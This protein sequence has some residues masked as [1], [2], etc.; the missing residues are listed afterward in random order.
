M[1]YEIRK[2]YDRIYHIHFDRQFDLCMTFLRVQEFY[3]SPEFKDHY[4]T[5]ADF[6]DWYSCGGDFTYVTD[7]DGFNVPSPAIDEFFELID[8][9]DGE[10][11]AFDA[12]LATIHKILSDREK[13]DYYLIGTYSKEDEIDQMVLNHEIAH[14]LFA[15]NFDYRRKMERLI[16]KLP[17]QK[18]VAKMSETLDEY[19]YHRAMHRDE[20][21]A[22]FATGL[23]RVMKFG[24]YVK[25]FR[26]VFREH[27]KEITQVAPELILRKEDTE[28][29][30][31]Q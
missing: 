11:N 27:K 7:W 31:A 4:F 5:V 18:V 23:D 15:S 26:A 2:I 10:W 28:L 9:Y 29:I 16:N 22:Y 8:Y 30:V 24:P 20:L 17:K 25:P 3:E 1:H 21:Q 13:G 12:E 14:A 6:M 19:G